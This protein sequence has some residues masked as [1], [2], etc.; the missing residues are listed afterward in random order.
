MLDASFIQPYMPF[1]K[2]EVIEKHAS[3]CFCQRLMIALTE[4]IKDQLE[5]IDG[6]II[7]FTF[8]FLRPEISKLMIQNA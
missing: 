5:D 3:V 7:I 1:Q 8:V 6:Y 2:V 4:Y